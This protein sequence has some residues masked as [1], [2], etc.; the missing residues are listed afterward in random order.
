MYVI[1][2]IKSTEIWANEFIKGNKHR[3][4][5]EIKATYDSFYVQS[6]VLIY[7]LLTLNVIE[8]MIYI[9]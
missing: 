3:K 4:I 8:Y 1:T 6:D 5:Y 9:R 7:I 2:L